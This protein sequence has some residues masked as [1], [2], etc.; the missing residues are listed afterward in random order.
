MSS[1][2]VELA[3]RHAIA[4]TTNATSVPG[5]SVMRADVTRARVPSVLR[6]S[7]CYLVQGAKEVT[8]G[9]SVYRYRKSEFLFASVDLPVTGEVIEATT[10]KPYLCLALEIDPNLVLELTSAGI[11]P[12][13]ASATPAAIFV[14]KTDA[15]MTDAFLR[16]MQSL[17]RPMD[18][19]V[20]APSIVREIIYRVL[21]GPYGNAVR[22]L[23]IAKSQVRRIAKV[24]ERLKRDYRKPLRM[25]DLRAPRRH[26]PLVVPRAL[27][28]GHDAE[29]APVPEATAPPGG[30]P[31]AHRAGRPAPP[32]SPSRSATRAP[33]SSA[34]STPRCS[35]CRRSRR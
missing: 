12:P 22:D 8:V 29:P 1:E 30:A 18:A 23:G 5:F 21:S 31:P 27:S 15:S 6:P 25:D 28:Q 19:R 11:A 4:P 13:P 35:A 3:L 34:A 32:T 24:I 16:L 10:G 7:L 17:D 2:L 14:G 20:L 9:T 26:E 33:R